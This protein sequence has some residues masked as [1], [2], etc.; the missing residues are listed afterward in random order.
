[1]S[2]NKFSI[3]EDKSGEK[4]SRLM[5]KG[6]ASSLNAEVLQRKLD[7]VLKSGAKLI[8]VNMQD[9]SFLASGGIRVLLMYYKISRG[10]GIDFFIEAPSENVRNVLGMVA[11]DEML[12]R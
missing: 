6:P 7:E 5:V 3:I 10:R 1:M 9:V 12:L 11:L 8:I 2:D 4:T